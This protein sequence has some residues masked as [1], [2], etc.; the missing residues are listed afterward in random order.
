MN[1]YLVRISY[2]YNLNNNQ[3]IGNNGKNII[4][5]NGNTKVPAAPTLTTDEIRAIREKT[6]KGQKADAIVISKTDL[7]RMKQAT[8]IQTK[9]Q[10]SQ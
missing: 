2:K 3:I 8:K 10:A 6:E 5:G 9:E 7:D 1:H 4:A